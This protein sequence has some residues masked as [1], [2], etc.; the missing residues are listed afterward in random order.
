MAYLY[1]SLCFLFVCYGCGLFQMM[2]NLSKSRLWPTDGKKQDSDVSSL[3]Q[4][5]GSAP[6]DKLG[7]Y[8]SEVN[9]FSYRS[10][11]TGCFVVKKDSS[12]VNIHI[13]FVHKQIKLLT[14]PWI[15]IYNLCLITDKGHQEIFVRNRY[16]TVFPMFSISLH[17]ILPS[18]T[19]LKFEMFTF[20]LSDE[21]VVGVK[22]SPRRTV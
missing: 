9:G 20:P 1:I 18:M 8:S 6:L 15:L 5:P 11:C 22:N 3:A 7:L 17:M 2:I 10:Q 12:D 16:R 4:G 13:I 14:K 19:N 21:C